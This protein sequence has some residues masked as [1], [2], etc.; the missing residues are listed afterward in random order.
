VDLSWVVVPLP[1]ARGE[2]PV[3]FD[4]EVAEELRQ[5]GY[6]EDEATGDGAEP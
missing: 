2:A 5:L 1:T 3:A 6:L 4:A